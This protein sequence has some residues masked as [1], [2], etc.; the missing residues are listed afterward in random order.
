MFFSTIEVL[1]LISITLTVF[2]FKIVDYPWQALLV[3]IVMNLMSY[4]LRDQM[5]ISS[6]APISN[7]IL[8]ALL[9][10]VFL[11]VPLVWSFIMSIIGMALYIIIQASIV[12]VSF[13]Q[14]SIS[15][16]DASA[17][18]GYLIQ[19]VTALI[20]FLASYILYKFGIG[21][22]AD[23]DKL[24]FKWER[25]VVLT[26]IVLITLSLGALLYYNE[27]LLDILFLIIA[28][29]FF[30]FYTTKKEVESNDSKVSPNHGAPN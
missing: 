13:G 24:H 22:A 5:D 7:V 21:Y 18:Q 25:I 27:L 28:F 29:L 6:L 14:L 15:S 9:A 20:F 17:G 2:R 12:A 4:V 19:S 26:M 8:L 30:F 16:A 11:R 1:A 23:F 3:G 10:A